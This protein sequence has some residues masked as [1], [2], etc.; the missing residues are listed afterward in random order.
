MIR[1]FI[2]SPAG[3]VERPRPR[4]AIL[5][6]YGGFGVCLRPEY[7]PEV[8]AWVRAGGVFAIACLRG[9]GEEGEEWHHAGRKEN[10]QNV[11]DDFDAAT[12][13]LIDAG[14]TSRDQLGIMGGSNGGLLVGAALTQHP[15][16]YAAVV[17]MAPLLDMARY[18]LSGLGPSWRPEYGSAED[19]SEFRVLLSY[20]PYHRIG[21]GTAYPPVLFAAA[22]G[23]TRVAPAHAMKMCAA[24][25]HASSG[26]GPVLFRYERGVGHG[27]RALSQAIALVTDCLAF[28]ADRLGLEKHL[29]KQ[30]DRS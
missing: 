26:H 17:C 6:G 4:P 28:L 5:T 7:S 16:K 10:K 18:E 20:S 3:A 24:L 23:D 12:D 22:E 14:W 13:Y 9:G 19:P 2:L 29:E 30:K 27:A 21:F 1:M 15:D 25:Q 11:F 8:L